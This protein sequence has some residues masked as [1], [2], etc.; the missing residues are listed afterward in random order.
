MGNRGEREFIQALRA[1]ETR[2]TSPRTTRSPRSAPLRPTATPS[3][4]LHRGRHE[5][6]WQCGRDQ[7]RSHLRP[8]SKWSRHAVR[9]RLYLTTSSPTPR[10]YGDP[11]NLIYEKKLSGL[12]ELLPLLEAV[13]RT[14]KPL[15]IIAE[16]VEGDAL[17]PL[18]V[19][20][21]RS[22]PSKLR[23]LAKCLPL[24]NLCISETGT[25]PSPIAPCRI[26]VVN[27]VQPRIPITEY[28][29]FA[30]CAGSER[31]CPACGK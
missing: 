21:S 1:D 4:P 9:P 15:L 28:V 16:D 31:V 8:S 19:M 17:A 11:H 30:I 27:S 2:R 6:G 25:S 13:E 14:A 20:V 26:Q 3:Q 29:F 22:R 5:Q 12:S 10:R 23:A 24:E 18:V 7:R